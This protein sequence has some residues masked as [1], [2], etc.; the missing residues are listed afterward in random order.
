MHSRYSAG[1]STAA[2]PGVVWALAYLAKA[3]AFA[4]GSRS[5]LLWRTAFDKFPVGVR[6]GIGGTGLI[7]AD[8]HRRICGIY[9]TGEFAVRMD[10]KNRSSGSRPE[11]SICSGIQG[12]RRDSLAI[13]TVGA[14]S[15]TVWP[16]PD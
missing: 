7:G 14:S 11:Q 4:H 10:M 2:A 16:G 12:T 5:G 3:S 15:P 1:R 8:A 13:I 6:C 9:P